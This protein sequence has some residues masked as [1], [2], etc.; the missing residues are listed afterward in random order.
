[1]Q[2]NLWHL[3]QMMLSTVWLTWGLHADPFM[4]DQN[5]VMSVLTLEEFG[6]TGNK[7]GQQLLW[8]CSL[9]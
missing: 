7:V 6:A 8:C 3:S 1:M 5:F 2:S 9:C 4:N